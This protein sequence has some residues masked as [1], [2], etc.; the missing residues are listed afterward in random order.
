MP[1]IKVNFLHMVWKSNIRIE[2]KYI[3][4]DIHL[5]N[6]DKVMMYSRTLLKICSKLIILLILNVNEWITITNYI[7]RHSTSLKI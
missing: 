2:S 6:L 1:H 5:Y 3:G 7:T 4:E